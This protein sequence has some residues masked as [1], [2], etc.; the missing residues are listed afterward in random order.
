VIASF[1]VFKT[2]TDLANSP[3][4]EENEE[5]EKILLELVI[6]FGTPKIGIRDIKRILSLVHGVHH[7]MKDSKEEPLVSSMTYPS[8]QVGK[9]WINHITSIWRHQ[10]PASLI[11]ISAVST[12]SLQKP[13]SFSLPTIS[14]LPNLSY[15][16]DV[17][18]RN[19]FRIMFETDAWDHLVLDDRLEKHVFILKTNASSHT[20]KVSDDPAERWRKH[21]DHRM[22][23]LL[24]IWSEMLDK[25]T[26]KKIKLLKNMKEKS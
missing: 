9:S 19:V 14:D 11:P 20:M 21:Y 26:E 15:P 12:P 6:R 7:T 25:I 23:E 18:I 24:E 10:V 3:L 16:S 8:R 1:K 5:L 2:F 4:G 17:V 13:Q 22:G